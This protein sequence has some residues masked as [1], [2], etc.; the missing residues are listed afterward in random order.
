MFNDHLIGEL[1]C[2]IGQPQR[3]DE[4]AFW[5]FDDMSAEAV[6][7]W[8]DCLAPSKKHRHNI[9]NTKFI[10][11]NKMKIHPQLRGSGLGTEMLLRFEALMRSLK[12]GHIYLVSSQLWEE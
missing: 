2:T 7:F 5:F 10:Y 1:S 4:S 11:L 9:L 6:E 3:D 12:V 8:L